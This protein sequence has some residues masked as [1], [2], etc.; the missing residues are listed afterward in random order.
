MAARRAWSPLA[1]ARGIAGKGRGS[2]AGTIENAAGF[3]EFPG[4]SSGTLGRSGAP[5]NGPQSVGFSRRKSGGSR[6]RQSRVARVGPAFK[7]GRAEGKGRLPPDRKGRH[8]ERGGKPAARRKPAKDGGSEVPERRGVALRTKEG[9]PQ[10]VSRIPLPHM[11]T[12]FLCA[13][14]CRNL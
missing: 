12:G 5:P 8:G 9:I 11:G 14:F 4:C 6:R 2:P 3:G 7:T 13:A 1:E 10:C